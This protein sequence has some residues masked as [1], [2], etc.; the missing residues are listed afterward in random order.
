MIGTPGEDSVEKSEW[1]LSSHRAA[2]EF[3]RRKSIFFVES[4][5]SCETT[6]LLTLV[7]KKHQLVLDSGESA[8]RYILC[9]FFFCFKQRN[10]VRSLFTAIAVFFLAFCFACTVEF[11]RSQVQRQPAAST[12]RRTN[13]G[14]EDSSTWS[15]SGQESKSL[16]TQVHPLLIAGV[17]V[18]VSYGCL[19]AFD[20]EANHRAS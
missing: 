12:W 7:E 3:T 18:L 14:W 6:S 19:L 11:P 13:D 8:T 2:W 15:V 1:V 10:S 17:Q 9:S 4:T 5:P 20:N 16:A